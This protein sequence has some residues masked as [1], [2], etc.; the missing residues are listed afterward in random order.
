MVLF[1]TPCFSLTDNPYDVADKWLLQEDLPLSYRQ[2][3]V[4]FILQNTGQAAAL[5]FGASIPDPYT[6]GALHT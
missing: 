1:L 2:Q 4:D 5:P 6:G 3:I